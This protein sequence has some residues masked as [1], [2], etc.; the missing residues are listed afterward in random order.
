MKILPG[1]LL[2]VLST[3]PALAAVELQFPGLATMSASETTEFASYKMP[4]GPYSSGDIPTVIAEGRQVQSS[5][6][7][8]LTGGSTLGIMDN[9]RQQI[10][11]VGFELLYECETR[12]CGGFDFRF[13]TMV[14]PEPAMHVDL[15]DFRYLSAQRLGGAVPEYVSL[16]VSR[17]LNTG[18]VQM[19]HVGAASAED[20]TIAG[21]GEADPAAAPRPAALVSGSLIETL[22]RTGSAVLEDLEFSTGSSELGPG[23][24]GSLSDL[25]AYLTANPG[26]RIALVGHTDAEGSRE[27]NIALSRQRARSVAARLQSEFGVTPSQIISDGVGFLAPRASNLTE[28]G[29]TKNRRVE[30]VL[31]STQ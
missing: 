30:V 26:R 31:T 7:V 22:E 4:I 16:L 21:T 5:W 27:G 20:V 10:E 15:G 14:L 9:L 1:I 12:E 19:I 25:A 11:A 28:E 17:S 23:N 3:G 2:S 13:E 6:H 24:F 29:R 8:Q 18:Y